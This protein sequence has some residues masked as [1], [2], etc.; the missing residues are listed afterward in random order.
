VVVYEI[1]RLLSLGF[2]YC[3]LGDAFD[4]FIVRLFEVKQGFCLAV[5]NFRMKGSL[6]RGEEEE[7]A[8]TG[9]L[10]VVA[11]LGLVHQR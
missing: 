8:K 6:V 1:Y 7:L 10:I 5:L 9:S 4:R 3:T 2:A 11:R